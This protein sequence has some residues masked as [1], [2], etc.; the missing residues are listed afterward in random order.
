M[1]LILRFNTEILTDKVPCKVN[2]IS[3]FFPLQKNATLFCN[4]Y[5]HRRQD[6]KKSQLCKMPLRPG[7]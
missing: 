5:T 7:A 3:F 1:L 2:S 6:H 4:V